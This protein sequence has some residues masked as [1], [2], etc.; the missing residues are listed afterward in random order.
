MQCRHSYCK[1]CKWAWSTRPFRIWRSTAV[2][3]ACSW[4]LLASPDATLHLHLH[5]ERE[6]FNLA[7]AVE[8]AE[9]VRHALRKVAHDVLTASAPNATVPYAD[10]LSK[11]ARHRARHR[12]FRWIVPIPELGVPRRHV[13]ALLHF[14]PPASSLAWR[15]PTFSGSSSHVLS[16]HSHT[17]FH[18]RCKPS[19]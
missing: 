14:P 19:R 9:C 2:A 16:S 1:S 3:A 5:H 10:I 15:F 8:A 13:D 4:V 18:D 11:G 12:A 6:R 7:G 17:C